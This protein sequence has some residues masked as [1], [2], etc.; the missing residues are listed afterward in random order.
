MQCRH[1]STTDWTPPPAVVVGIDGAQA[2]VSAALW[3]ADEA[4][5]LGVPLRL[6]CA[7]D[8]LDKTE[9]HTAVRHAVAAVKAAGKPL[10]I[11]SDITQGTS[12]AAL[13][14]ASRAAAMVCVGALGLKHF[15][16]R[17][18]RS[19]AAALARSAQCSVAVVRRREGPVGPPPGKVVVELDASPDNGVVL[20]SAVHEADLRRAPLQ[21]MSCW[22]SGLSDLANPRSVADTNGRLR[23][24][25]DRRLEYW[26]RRYPEL[27]VTAVALHGSIID[28][29]A[30]DASVQL[31][32][33]GS[34]NRREVAGLL[35]PSGNVA[36]NQTGCSVL[37]VDHRHL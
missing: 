34:R 4:V 2:A 14:R 15:Q 9:A 21:V 6:V 25:L 35:G 11:E 13:L 1:S 8:Q 33:V 16:R 23:A 19:T 36:L 26:T 22:Q 18:V 31:V 7:T 28:Y 17:G 27:D 5:S 32:V 24:C 3:A 10:T 37:I 30:N 20:E 29:L 12:V